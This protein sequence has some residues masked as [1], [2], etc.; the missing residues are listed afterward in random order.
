M[1]SNHAHD[2]PFFYF[3]TGILVCI[4]KIIQKPCQEFWKFFTN[5]S[6]TYHRYKKNQ[7][8]PTFGRPLPWAPLQCV[9]IEK[10]KA[11]LS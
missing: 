8:K 2:S 9:R 3:I 5:N 10:F 4:K 6:L 1:L 7:T 11:T